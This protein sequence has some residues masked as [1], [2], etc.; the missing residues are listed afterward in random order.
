[1]EKDVHVTF[2]YILLHVIMVLAVPSSLAIIPD[3]AIEPNK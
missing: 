1:M 2:S 3:H